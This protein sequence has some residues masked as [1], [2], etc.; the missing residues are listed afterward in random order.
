MRTSLLLL[1]VF[2]LHLTVAAKKNVAA[3]AVSS[4]FE[5]ISLL[6]GF[7]QLDVPQNMH[8]DREYYHYW[9]NCPDGGYS[10]SFKGACSDKMGMT[11]QI[12][13]H[14]LPLDPV[15]AHDGYDPRKHCLNDAVVLHDIT[16]RQGDKMYTVIA[17]LAKAGKKNRPR[18]HNY[19]LNYYVY[20]DNRMLEF[21]YNYWSKDGGQL[22]YWEHVSYVMA[23]SISWQSSAGVVAQK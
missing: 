19:T 22:K 6:N 7:L 10:V 2:C 21:Q 14:D 20:S 23:N 16:F 17:T 15:H 4:S 11:V 8:K 18:T 9:D 3:S 13:V 5:R 1:A 12:N